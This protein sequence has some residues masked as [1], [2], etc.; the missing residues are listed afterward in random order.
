MFVRRRSLDPIFLP[1]PPLAQP[2]VAM[3]DGRELWKG[4]SV[5][6]HQVQ[7]LIEKGLFPVGEEGVDWVLPGGE[8]IPRPLEEFV[9]S[10]LPFYERGFATPAGR[11]LQELLAAYQVELQHLFPIGILHAVVFVA[12]C[13]GF[14][15]VRPHLNLWR[16]LFWASPYLIVS[17]S[18]SY[19]ISMGCCSIRLRPGGGCWY[20]FCTIKV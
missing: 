12:L 8:V 13:E 20:F 6:L 18:R 4:S 2:T 5:R 16:H 17:Q 15:G 9:V 10:F 3:V 7:R 14:L 19:S 11:F 1:P